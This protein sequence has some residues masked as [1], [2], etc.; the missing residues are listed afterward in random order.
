MN[1]RSVALR[2]LLLALA[3]F[4][5][6][7]AGAVHGLSHG[8]AGGVALIQLAESGQ[9]TEQGGS[10]ASHICLDCLAYSALD[11][12]LAS[13]PPLPVLERQPMEAA[14]S[15]PAGRSVD[16]PLHFQSRAPPSF[17]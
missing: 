3:L 13:A 8:F 1:H 17:S 12:P 16:A 11:A 14:G 6:Q 4:W 5:A 10:S 7:L 15:L 2:H 9:P